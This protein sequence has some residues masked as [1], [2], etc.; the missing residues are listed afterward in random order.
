MRKSI[1]LLT[2]TLDC[3]VMEAKIL[4]TQ[5]I[6]DTDSVSQ[7]L[8][9]LKEL[10]STTT[11]PLLELHFASISTMILVDTLGSREQLTLKT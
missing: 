7:L 5:P 11:E 3:L 10:L 8:N 6:R 9:L 2:I 1:L 4:P